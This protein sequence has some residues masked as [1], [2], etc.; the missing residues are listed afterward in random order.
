MNKHIPPRFPIYCVRN[1]M[2][3][4]YR[5][6]LSASGRSL[7]GHTEN[8]PFVLENKLP[9]S[10]VFSVY[11]QICAWLRFLFNIGNPKQMTVLDNMVCAVGKHAKEHLLNKQVLLFLKALRFFSLLFLE[12]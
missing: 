11:S 7:P 2:D 12:E 9:V 1:I 6:K 4:A 3:Q 8:Y 10:G 5:Q